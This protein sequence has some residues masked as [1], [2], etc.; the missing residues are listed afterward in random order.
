MGPCSAAKAAKKSAGGLQKP[1]KC[2]EPLAA[3]IGACAEAR[4]VIV[5]IFNPS[6]RPGVPVPAH[7]Q[8]IHVK[9]PSYL[10]PPNQP[11]N[12]PHNIQSDSTGLSRQRAPNHPFNVHL[13]MLSTGETQISRAML[14]SKMWAYF[15]VGQCMLTVSKPVLKAPTISA[16]EGT[17]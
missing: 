5:Y 13:A 8:P 6:T 14:T 12:V 17:I 3:F 10:L 9:P 11:I 15:K 7:L 2:S 16:P 4:P 1:Y